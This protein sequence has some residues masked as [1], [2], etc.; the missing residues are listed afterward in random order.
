VKRVFL[1]LFWLFLLAPTAAFAQSQPQIQFALEQDTVGVGDV[2][3][4][5]MTVTSSTDAPSGPRIGATP[6][7]SVRGQNESPTQTHISINGNQMDRYSLTVDWTLQAQRMGN[8]NLG[9]PSV[10]VGGTRFTT[11]TIPIHVVAAG[12]A[13]ARRAPRQPQMQSPF[14]FSPFDP[15]KSL[16]PGMDPFDQMQPQ[17]Q[18]QLQTDPKLSVEP[19]RGAFYFLHATIDKTSAVVGEQVTFSIYEYLDVEATDV[20]IGEDA[21]DAQVPD[22]V[23]RAIMQEDQDAQLVGYATA[24]GRTWVVKLVRRWALFP[25]KTGDLTIGPMIETMVR[26]RSVAGQT[27]TTED[28][29]V[30]VTEPPVGGRPPGYALGDVGH[31]AL[32]ATVT[33]RDIEQGGAVGVHVELSGTGN[34]P[35]S[36]ATGAREGVEWLTPEVHDE[37]GATAH[38]AYGGKRSFDYVVRMSKP[39]AV[40]LGTLTLPFWN[41]DQ[42]RYEVARAPLGSVH[43]APSASAG[44]TAD[45]APPILPGLPDPRDALSGRRAARP[46]ADDSASFWIAGIAGPP[47][48]FAFAV[49][50]RRAGR[51]IRKAWSGRRASPAA[52]L[53]ERVALA[54]A[55]CGGKDARRADAAIARALEAATVVHAGVSVRAAVGGEVI[56]RLE[57]AGVAPEDALTVADLLRECEAARFSPDDVDVLSARDRWSRA[58]GVIR[59]LEKRG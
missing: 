41:P 23:K 47:L 48:A 3:R 44:A 30:H 36:L 16:M 38:D 39:G 19:P 50:G 43:V 5:Q 59:G 8:F 22:F 49:V 12:K 17:Q 35:S 32:S 4:L 13:P 27:R 55:A 18:P 20:A 40:D 45:I 10:M 26:P 2:V 15:W 58:Q 25:L 11:Q 28:L 57:R 53:K 46:H 51:R 24:G 1:F 37:V 52:D 31:F 54:H 56:E 33:P 21:R 34:L 14:G 7:F 42:K 9:P 6:G 29:R